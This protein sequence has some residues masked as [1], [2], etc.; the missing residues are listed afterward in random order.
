MPPSASP[1]A[2]CACVGPAI[3]VE[4]A[5]PS[6]AI[7]LCMMPA[8][9]NDHEFAAQLAFLAVLHRVDDDVVHAARDVLPASVDE[10]P[11]VA[12]GLVAFEPRDSSRSRG[13]REH[14]PR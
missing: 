9:A 6:R 14:G 4:S 3:S 13:P 1:P 7:G 11:G 5:T 8:S 2:N 12:H 10:R